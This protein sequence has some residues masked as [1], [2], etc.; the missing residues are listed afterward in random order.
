MVSPLTQAMA[1]Q[2]A[3]N[4]AQSGIAPTDVVG[5]YR[6][7]SDVAERNYQ[8]KLAANN[9][10][11]GGLAG[12]GGAGITAFGPSIA[13]NYFGAGVGNAAGAA[14][15]AVASNAAAGAAAP[16]ATGALSFAPESASG[17]GVDALGGL[18]TGSVAADMGLG[19]GAAADAGAGSVLADL[20]ANGAGAGAVDAAASTLPDWLTSFLPFLAV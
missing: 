6:L 1:F 15:P 5:S 17:F 20:G 12:L 19:G 18:G 14:T 8:A 16:G 13:K 3:V 7:A 9:A 11:W 2:G 10:M 4:P